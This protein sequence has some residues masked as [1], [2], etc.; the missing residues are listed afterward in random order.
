MKQ[1]QLVPGKVGLNQDSR[2]NTHALTRQS[3][4]YR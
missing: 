1:L 2:R 3:R 4:I